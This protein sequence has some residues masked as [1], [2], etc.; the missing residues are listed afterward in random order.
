[1]RKSGANTIKYADNTSS[2]PDV[3]VVAEI[4]PSGG[5]QPHNNM[6]PYMTLNWIIKY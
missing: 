5:N 6:P 2:E 3:K 1:L 4:Q